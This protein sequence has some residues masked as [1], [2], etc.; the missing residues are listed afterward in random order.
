M[1]DKAQRAKF[2]DL[3]PFMLNVL[4]RTLNTNDMNAAQTVVESFIEIAVA[5]PSFFK[6]HAPNVIMAMF[7]I[8]KAKNLDESVRHLAMEFMVALAE[9]SPTLVRKIPNYVENIFP[10]S[11][12][13]MVM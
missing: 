7:Q 11:L 3:L 13:M 1:L 12:E 10:L 6:A 8:A 5:A 2:C 4:A 9:S